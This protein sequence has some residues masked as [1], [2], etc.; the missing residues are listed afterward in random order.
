MAM[1]SPDHQ[2]ESMTVYMSGADHQ[3]LLGRVDYL[4]VGDTE[5][6]AFRFKH[7]YSVWATTFRQLLRQLLRE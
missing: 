4:K 2:G 3:G 1:L 5:G 7:F 6:M